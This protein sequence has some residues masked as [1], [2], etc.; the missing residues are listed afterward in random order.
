MTLLSVVAV[1]EVETSAAESEEV[2]AVDAV[3][4]EGSGAAEGM[5][6]AEL[7][8]ISTAAVAPEETI[9]AELEAT[10]EEVAKGVEESVVA[11]GLT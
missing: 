7:D 2:V 5:L 6:K 10:A 1:A 9:D 3:G 4:V 8:S 11:V